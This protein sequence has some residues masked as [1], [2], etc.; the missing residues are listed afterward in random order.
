M[1]Q[2]TLLC[3]GGRGGAVITPFWGCVVDVVMGIASVGRVVCKQ[4]SKCQAGGCR[5]TQ[6]VT[7]GAGEQLQLLTEFQG[8][9][10]PVSQGHL[11]PSQ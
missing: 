3:V 9:N 7:R 4:C 11:A 1:Q 10:M 6:R 8:V 5:T 2:V